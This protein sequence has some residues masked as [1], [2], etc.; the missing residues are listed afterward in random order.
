MTSKAKLLQVFLS[1]NTTPG[2]GVFE[3]SV[4]E[5]D[6]LF[7][8]CPGFSSRRTCKHVKFVLTRIEENGGTYPLEISNR[9]TPDDAEAAK[10]SHIAFRDFIIKYGKIE[11]F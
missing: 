9:A 6:N 8:N 7:C 4:D 2:P 10:Y 3:V 11:V 5:S 1:K